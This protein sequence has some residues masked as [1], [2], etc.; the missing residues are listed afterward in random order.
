MKILIATRNNDKF[1]IIEKLLKSTIYS[2]SE[3]Y[4]LNEL[5]EV[6]EE[7]KETGNIINR[8]QEKAYTVY[9]NITN[10]DFDYIIGVD[11]GIEMKS[12]LVENV[13]DYIEDIIND[14]FLIEKEKIFIVRAFSFINKK[15]NEK[16]I[17][18]KIPFVY[19]K[20]EKKLEILNNTYPL[21]YV[22][23]E[24]NK[25]VTISNQN[26]EDSN[27]YYK[28]YSERQLNEVRDYYNDIN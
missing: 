8:A 27:N 1:K 21:S 11:D 4:S 20:T 18:T 5:E 28:L 26:F 9:N 2:S 19:K 15:G 6:I 12:K 17:I 25:N 10:N 3:F 16:S 7:K 23:T 24:V 14:K 13:K 22:L